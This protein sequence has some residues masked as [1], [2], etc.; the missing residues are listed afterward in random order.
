[1]TDFKDF[2]THKFAYVSIGEFKAGKFEEA[3]QIYDEAVSA[4]TQ[5]FKGAYLL[6]QQ[7]TDKGIS[8]TFWDSEESMKENINDA[9][10]AILKK[11]MPLFVSPPTTI[12]YEVVSEIPPVD[13]SIKNSNH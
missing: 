3:K 5:G 12:S 7:G 10:K 2:L 1:M 6:Q 9:H 8:V 11:I 4:Y 13:G